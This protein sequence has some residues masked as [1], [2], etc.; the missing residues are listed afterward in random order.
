[1]PLGWDYWFAVGNA[2]DSLKYD[3]NED[4]VHRTFGTQ[5][6]DP[7]NYLTDVLRGRALGFL[8]STSRLT[9]SF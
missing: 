7:G 3:A 1:M 6:E 5:I 4:G 2:Y 9:R 8:G